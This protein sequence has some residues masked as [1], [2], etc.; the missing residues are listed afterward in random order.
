MLFRRRFAK[1]I[2]RQLDLFAE[3][4]AG[5][6]ERIDDARER[7]TA[8]PR[9][10]AEDQFGEYQAWVTDGTD[11]LVRLRENFAS[12]LNDDDA[13]EYEQAFNRA[14]Q[15]RF[16]DLALELEEQEYEDL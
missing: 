9:A 3:E 6:L 7:Y 4:H 12:T 13:H 15:R 2:D 11:V 14:V 8:A 1:V 5:L 16:G 10:D